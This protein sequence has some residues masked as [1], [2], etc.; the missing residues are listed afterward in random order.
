MDTSTVAVTIPWTD[1]P[2]ENRKN[3]EAAMAA[4][5]TEINAE[6]DDNGEPRKYRV[7]RIPVPVPVSLGSHR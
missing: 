5:E 6:L 7:D 1:D 4:G 3:I 2:V